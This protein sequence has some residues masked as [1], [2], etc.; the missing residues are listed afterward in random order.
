VIAGG[1]ER[2]GNGFGHERGRRG[3]PGQLYKFMIRSAQ[4]ARLPEVSGGRHTIAWAPDEPVQIHDR[5]HG[6]ELSTAFL[7]NP[8]RRVLE[9]Q[10]PLV[11]RVDH[12]D[13]AIWT[14]IDIFQVVMR[15]FGAPLPRQTDISRAARF[16]PIRRMAPP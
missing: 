13:D 16:L 7:N 9:T 10:K 11:L 8:I 2:F 12:L 15:I 1:Q 4:E 6:V 5:Q 14:H 3:E